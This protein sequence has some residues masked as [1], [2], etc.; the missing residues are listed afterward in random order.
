MT[1]PTLGSELEI[2]WR[3]GRA[4]FHSPDVI[5]NSAAAYE[6]LFQVYARATG[7][8]DTLQVPTDWNDPDDA[9]NSPVRS[10]S[11]RSS[12]AASVGAGSE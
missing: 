7:D 9:P 1:L 11:P 10:D 2:E 8:V 6:D 4:D 5:R 12:E 3:D